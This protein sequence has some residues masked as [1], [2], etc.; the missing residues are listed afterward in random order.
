[1]TG[2]GE[3][4]PYTTILNQKRDFKKWQIDPLPPPKPGLTH[5]L[6]EIREGVGNW[7]E[8]MGWSTIHHRRLDGDP[9]YFDGD[10]AYGVRI[11]WDSSDLIT[12]ELTFSRNTRHLSRSIHFLKELFKERV[13]PSWPS[14]RL[15][16]PST[17]GIYSA[18]E[19]DIA[20][21]K[22]LYRFLW[23]LNYYSILSL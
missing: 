2:T 4:T 19:I 22:Y 14:L 1:M 8:E 6:R 16:P 11:D 9:A 23:I 20:S 10:P 5:F 21:N 18:R 12:N 3:D 17:N 7:L 13:I 15:T